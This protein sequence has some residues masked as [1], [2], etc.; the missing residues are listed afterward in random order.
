VGGSRVHK[1]ERCDGYAACRGFGVGDVVGCCVYLA[2]PTLG[3]LAVGGLAA[4]QY[5]PMGGGFSSGGLGGGGGGGGFSGGTTGSSGADS[6]SGG[7]ALAQPPELSHLDA[8]SS[9]VR[10]YVNGVDQVR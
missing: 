8:S 3:P 7:G 5:L 1:S 2:P 9:H 10:F 4:G 6:S